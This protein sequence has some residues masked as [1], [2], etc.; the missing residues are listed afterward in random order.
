MRFLQRGLL[1]LFALISVSDA[2]AAA[3]KSGVT[4]VSPRLA[5]T[6]F[7][8]NRAAFSPV[9]AVEK[10]FINGWGIAIRPAG[11]GGHFWVTAKDVSYEYVGD[12]SQSP[13]EKLR[14][15]QT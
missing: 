3:E 14:A 6:N 10:A 8:G 15:L 1:C 5:Q 9:F 7:V 4:P 2:V 13:D 11:A 12:V